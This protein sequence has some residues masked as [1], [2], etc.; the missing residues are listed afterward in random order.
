MLHVSN[1]QLMITQVDI[2]ELLVNIREPGNEMSNIKSF[3]ILN[4]DDLINDSAVKEVVIG[5]NYLIPDNGIKVYVTSPN[6][7]YAIINDTR[8]SFIRVEYTS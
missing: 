8:N 4:T 2:I 6:S 1:I 7:R 3:D 5:K